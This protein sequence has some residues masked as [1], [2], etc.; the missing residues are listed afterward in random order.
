[1]G[2]GSQVS[3]GFALTAQNQLLQNVGLQFLYDLQYG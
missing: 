1:M 2:P 3:S